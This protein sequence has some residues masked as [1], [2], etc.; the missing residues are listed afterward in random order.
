[1]NWFKRSLI[2]ITLFFSSQA[3][4][5]DPRLPAG[6]ELSTPDG[7]YESMEIT[8]VLPQQTLSPC[9]FSTVKS[10]CMDEIPGCKIIQSDSSN[11]VCNYLSYETP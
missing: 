9:D 10:C 6:H 2:V 5:A 1:M 4:Y 11:N 3:L 8:C 7:S